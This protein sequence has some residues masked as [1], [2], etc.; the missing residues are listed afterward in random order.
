MIVFLSKMFSVTEKL[1]AN[2]K[3]IISLMLGDVGLYKVLL[4]N[5]TVKKIFYKYA[6][7]QTYFNNQ[8]FK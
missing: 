1:Q 8:V 5:C 6:I 7:I 3:S 2:L 4:H